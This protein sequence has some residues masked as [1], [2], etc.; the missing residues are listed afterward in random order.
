MRMR[1]GTRTLAGWVRAK[2]QSILPASRVEKDTQVINEE[3]SEIL[4][5]QFINELFR[6]PTVLDRRHDGKDA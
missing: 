2:L 4:L 1:R 6:Y 3:T 5:E